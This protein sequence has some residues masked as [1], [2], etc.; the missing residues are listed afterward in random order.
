MGNKKHADEDNTHLQLFKMKVMHD[1]Q[2]LLSCINLGRPGTMDSMVQLINLMGEKVQLTLLPS[3][4][5]SVLCAAQTIKQIFLNFNR[6]HHQGWVTLKM[7]SNLITNL[8]C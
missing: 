2:C 1:K 3:A 7:Y 6:N 5:K 4:Y 8:Q